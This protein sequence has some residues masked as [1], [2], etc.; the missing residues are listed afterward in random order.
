MT[1]PTTEQLQSELQDIVNQHSQAKQ[2][3]A[4]CTMCDSQGETYYEENNFDYS[5][6]DANKLQ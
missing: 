5:G 3:I 2:V 4:Q 6:V 1:K